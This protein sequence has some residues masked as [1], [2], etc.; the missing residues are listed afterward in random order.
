M[1]RLAGFADAV[2]RHPA[3]GLNIDIAVEQNLEQEI[4]MQKDRIAPFIHQNAHP[5]I[6]R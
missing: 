2:W 6:V 5:G 1:L 3:P 4:P